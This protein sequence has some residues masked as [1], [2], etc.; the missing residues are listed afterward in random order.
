MNK[1]NMLHTLS[2]IGLL[3]LPVAANART[4]NLFETEDG[5]QAVPANANPLAAEKAAFAEYATMTIEEII[6]MEVNGKAVTVLLHVPREADGVIGDDP[7]TGGT[8]GG[9]YDVVVFSQEY[10]E[11]M[12]PPGQAVPDEVSAVPLP[13]AG[14]LMMSGLAGMTLIARRRQQNAAAA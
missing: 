5:H 10:P 12:M 3:A 4:I 8:E 6:Q 7:G 13:A 14:W 1:T 11:G 9:G 2:L